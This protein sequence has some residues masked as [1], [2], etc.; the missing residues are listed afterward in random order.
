MIGKKRRISRILK[1][2][3]SVILP[4][5]HGV[6]KPEKGIEKIDRVLEDVQG[7]ID[8][9]IVHKGVV[10]RSGVIAEMEAGLIIHLSGSTVWAEDP[11][12]K[13]IVTSVE[14]AISLGADGVSVHVNIGSATEAIQ[15]Q[16]L[17]EI[18]EICDW[19][20]VPL[21]AMMYPR[22]KIEVNTESVKHA[23]RIGYELGADILKV[24]FTENFEDVVGFVDVPV[25]IAGGSKENEYDLFKK[26]E[27]AMARGAS[28]VAVGRNL[29]NSPSP[30][31][32]A[33]M[34]H[35]IVHSN[36]RA[37]DVV[38]YEGNLVVG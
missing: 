22:G 23:A 32:I 5:D 12:D 7:Y 1:N 18:S 10:K 20:G 36:M 27:D 8:A 15:L 17:G 24:P 14:R 3:R 37:K 21:L 34:L 25:V 19:Y 13:R 38:E 9:I 11:N 16:K 30:S 26:V 2:G 29:F 28:G 35:M 4:M 6:T 31:K 33:R